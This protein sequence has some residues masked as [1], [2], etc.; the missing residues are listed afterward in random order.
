MRALR[1]FF[2]KLVRRRR[3][4][5][6]LE[7]ELAFHRELAQA[8]DNP[9]R[10]G[11]V[12][13]VREEAL[14]AWRFAGVENLWRDVV[15][16]LRR[17]RRNAGYTTA[18]AGSLALGVGISTAMFAVLN[19]VAFRPLPYPQEPS[20]VWVSQILKAN[21]TDQ[22]TITGD[23]LDWQRM[24]HTFAAM[25]GM[26]YPYL[27]AVTGLGDSFEAR[28]A[29]ASAS[30]FGILQVKPARGRVFRK[31]EDYAGR[32]HVAVVSYSFWRD[33]LGGKSSAIGR[34]IGLDGDQYTVVGVLPQEFVFPGDRGPVDVITPLAKDK[35][36]DLARNGYVT[37]VH[38]IVARLKPG[39]R[40]AQ[41]QADLSA[42]Q[43][44]L[45][46]LPW[47]PTITIQVLPLREH[48]FG[49]QRTTALVLAGGSLLFLLLASANL[50]NLALAQLMQRD[51]ELA[52]RRALGASRVRVAMQLLI[53]NAVVATVACVAGVGVAAAIRNGLAALPQYQGGLYGALP[54]DGRVLLFTAAT[55]GAV[56]LVFGLI[57]AL[58][59]SDVRLNAAITAGQTNVAGRR[60]QLRYLS[61]VAMVEIAIVV[62]LS[63]SAVL[64]LESFW[65][66][67]Y[68]GLGFEPGHTVTATFTLNAARYA[69]SQAKTAFLNQVLAGVEA[70]PG[71]R[72]AAV[73]V[74]SEIP[75]GG[76]H[77]TNNAR[78]EGQT[79][80]MDSREKAVMRNQEVSAGYFKIL[81]IPLIAG[82]LLADTDGPDS[83]P[84]VVVSRDFERRY[85][86]Q[87]SAV[88]HR[89]QA[90]ERTGVWY[91]IVGVVGDVRSG[92]PASFP[93][94][95]VYTPYTQ[96]GPGR[97]HDLGVL[98]DSS[99]PVATLAPALRKVVA[100][101]DPQLPVD[102][103]ETLEKRL[104]EA[105]ARPR[106]TADL[107]GALSLLG[108][109]L[110]MIGVYGLTSC[111]VKAQMREI[112]VRQ[113]LGAPLAA[114]VRQMT[115]GAVLVAGVGLVA[116][117]ALAFASLQ[118][119]S[120]MLFQV[121][122]RDPLP[123]VEVGAGVFLA[124]LLACAVPAW[125]AGRADPL[126]TL[127]EN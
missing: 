60:F 45:P 46:T 122:W 21:S 26:N 56:V 114:I 20:L 5:A 67:R 1:R 7:A 110:A 61:L 90:G 43:A 25:A 71:V 13:A 81:R 53:E 62:A 77:A 82:R 123:F 78:I 48:L 58:R 40:P 75:P 97:A 38:D 2:L 88:G 4:E 118:V 103:I 10:L 87:Q 74:A 44:H 14:E 107:L 59:V 47:H 17:L 70:I 111:K 98:V 91:T 16:G 85:F 23:F 89:L 12:T 39:V 49:D 32:P 34:A 104:N 55:L 115:S 51:R 36:R 50:G 108:T 69:E 100:G 95:I 18:A 86:P 64:T 24:N 41:A 57:P 68:R 3:M 8:H 79:L 125:K 9:V 93:E 117:S 35:A 22:V 15:L 63:T 101:I 66:M 30:L 96:C 83:A 94:G 124:A 76:G 52:V 99:L 65:N 28:G 119:V 105:V 120:S 31:D 27:Y 127:R 92:G 42:I 6:D 33:R 126:E 113:A 72:Q 11:N 116:G 19:V 106:F 112:A 73:A 102:S 29:R 84:V 54:M 37:V 80:P 109:V 121:N